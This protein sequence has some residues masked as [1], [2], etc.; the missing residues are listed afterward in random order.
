MRSL[1]LFAL[2]AASPAAQAIELNVGTVRLKG[3]VEQPTTFAGIVVEPDRR[4]DRAVRLAIQESTIKFQS[5]GIE[6]KL[7]DLELDPDQPLSAQLAQIDQTHLLL[8]DLPKTQMVEVGRIIDR[9]GAVGVN[10]SLADQSLRDELCLPGIYHSMP[11]ER[12]YFDALSQY[13]VHSGWRKVLLVHGSSD[14]DLRRKTLL[15]ESIKRFG[16]SVSDEREFTLSHHPDD[17]D[18]N[19][20]EFLTGGS[21]Y[22]VVA[23]VDSAKDYGRRIEYSTRRPRPV[24]GDVGLV[25]RAWHYALERYGA[26]QLNQRYRTL[27]PANSEPQ[28][29]M[30]DAEFAAWAAVKFV[31]NSMRADFVDK[32]GL[33]LRALFE[34]EDSR[35]DLYKGTRGSYRSW[36]HQM[37]HPILLTSADYVVDV[38]PMPKFLHP[39]HYVDTLGAD[40]P[41]SSCQLGK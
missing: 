27:D 34:N 41:E 15:A 22:D 11:S 12:M 18:R 8:L 23:V 24:V 16:A 3:A 7:Y 19:Q 9:Q 32:D 21:S 2:L 33:K 39:T 5:F 38:A 20:P 25:P 13:L 28:T 1:V 31:V 36:N 35:V 29:A 17:R 14:Q 6:E 30:T 10:V 4:V 40:K 37:R 26:P